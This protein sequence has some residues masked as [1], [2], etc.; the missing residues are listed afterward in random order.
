MFFLLSSLICFSQNVEKDILKSICENMIVQNDYYLL[1]QKLT[2]FKVVEEPISGLK[3]IIYPPNAKSTSIDKFMK[4]NKEEK[5]SILSSF[6]FPIF[7]ITDTVFI[8]DSI[9]FFSED[10]YFLKGKQCFVVK[11]IMNKKSLSNYMILDAVGIRDNNLI[12]SFSFMHSKEI[13]NYFF[14]LKPDNIKLFKTSTVDKIPL[15][16]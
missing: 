16:E 12:I 14:Y 7:P 10:D 11:R 13:V 2:G 3:D 4:Y 5:I 1:K 6:Y 8:I 9:K 15:I